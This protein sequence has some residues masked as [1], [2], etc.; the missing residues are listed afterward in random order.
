MSSKN[1]VAEPLQLLIVL[2]YLSSDVR[3]WQSAMIQI[4]LDM[5]TV[6]SVLETSFTSKSY[7]KVMGSHFLGN[8]MFFSRL[9][10]RSFPFLLENNHSLSR[11]SINIVCNKYKPLVTA[12]LCCYP[13]Y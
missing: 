2:T 10:L 3:N 7:A 6:V 12:L 13:A 1:N 8:S 4:G 9:S 5:E 11:A